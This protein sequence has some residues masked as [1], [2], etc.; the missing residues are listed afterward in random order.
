MRTGN[1][2]GA[3]PAL[4]SSDNNIDGLKILLI[5]Q[6]AFDRPSS[7]IAADSIESLLLSS[8][9]HVDHCSDVYRGLARLGRSTSDS[10]VRAYDIAMICV[11]GFSSVE[12]EFFSI[13]A[14][15]YPQISIYV[16]SPQS[17]RV[18]LD[19][20]IELGAAGLAS[21]ELIQS[22]VDTQTTTAPMPQNVQN[23]SAQTPQQLIAG[24]T[25]HEHSQ[26]NLAHENPDHPVEELVMP[27][28]LVTP[29][30]TVTQETTLQEEELQKITP[31]ETRPQDMQVVDVDEIETQEDAFDLEEEEPLDD[32]QD[33]PAG[34]ARVPWIRYQNTPARTAPQPQ[35]VRQ[36][37]V[38]HET[39]NDNPQPVMRRNIDEPLLS[40][41]ELEALLG[42]DI[43]AIVPSE[44]DALVSDDAA[45]EENVT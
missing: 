9:L 15:R 34:P 38:A 1:A 3:R 25:P 6:P 16:Y 14:R 10:D 42:D 26:E 21:A 8:P 39:M 19:R 2:L 32:P 27:E 31:Q 5:H 23:E 4:T 11:D 18:R 30:D 20:A 22:I 44:R 28:E 13:V 12:L 33:E 43:S 29:P 45:G 37:P 35:P 36:P 7:A 24:E 41:E 17:S 40:E